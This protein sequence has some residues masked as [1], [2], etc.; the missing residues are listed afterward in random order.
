MMDGILVIDKPEGFTSFDVVAVMRR[1]LGEKKIG[2]T[3]TLDPMAT[4]VLPLLLGRAAK[5]AERLEDSRKEYQ[6]E[7][8]LGERTDTGDRTGRVI[9]KCDK[10]VSKDQLKAVLPLFWGE[11]F[12][13]PPMYSA[14]QK[15][16]KRLYEL[17]RQGIEVHRDARPVTIYRLELIEYQEKTGIG[18]V[19]VSCSKGTYI[20]TLCEDIA[21]AAGTLATMTSLRRTRA[22]GFTLQDA[23]PLETARQKNAGEL[24]SFIKPIDSLFSGRPA[25]TV[26][27]AQQI[28][29]C[30]GGAL[31][32]KRTGIPDELKK[33]GVRLR[34][35]GPEGAFLGMGTV[36]SHKGE[37]KILKLFH[38]LEGRE[39]L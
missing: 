9:D 7:F 28:R 16:G 29:F 23:L 19:D 17:A 33:D 18:R 13:V 14:V 2:H 25:V 10:T 21:A 11:I 27:P 6:A 15:D 38:L 32:L 34:V 31:D 8:R 5:A 4:G 22:C 30:N 36:D 24:A 1:V 20:R 3:G 39:C 35:Y 26:S 37:L 12:Q